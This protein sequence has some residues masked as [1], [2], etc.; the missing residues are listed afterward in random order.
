LISTHFSIDRSR[1]RRRIDLGALR[2]RGR[3]RRITL[4]ATGGRGR[5]GRGVFFVGPHRHVTKDTVGQLQIAFELLDRASARLISKQRVIASALLFDAI[6]KIAGASFID[7]RYR[8]ALTLD[9][10]FE[11]F[12]EFFHAHPLFRVNHEKGF[13]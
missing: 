11:P 4:R 3:L 9:N 12:D 2:F 1:L 7:L 13:I 10:L 6:G 5:I 8:T